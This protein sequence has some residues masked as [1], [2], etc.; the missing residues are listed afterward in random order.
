MFTRRRILWTCAAIALTAAGAALVALFELGAM[1]V[2]ASTA[3]PT[4][5]AATLNMDGRDVRAYLLRESNGINGEPFYT[6]GLYIERDEGAFHWYYV[7]HE[8]GLWSDYTLVAEPNESS[9][10]VHLD[11][12]RVGEYDASKGVYRRISAGE[13]V[14][15]DEPQ[16]VLPIAPQSIRIHQRNETR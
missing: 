14:I 10:V 6:V 8:A 2:G 9:F 7:D 13:I 15:F 16:D 12:E 5:E 4:V 1:I 11:N 3:P